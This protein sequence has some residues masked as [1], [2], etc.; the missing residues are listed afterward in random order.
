MVKIT[1]ILLALA[2]ASCSTPRLMLGPNAPKLRFWQ[3]DPP[4]HAEVLE[5][6]ESLKEKR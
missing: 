5:Y 6:C 4:T 2:L 3:P 1:L